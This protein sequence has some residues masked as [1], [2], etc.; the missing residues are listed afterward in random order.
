MLTLTPRKQHTTIT[1]WLY[2]ELR[3]AILEGR[4]RRGSSVPTTRA[5]G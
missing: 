2:E 1:Q 5:L 4:L 3:R